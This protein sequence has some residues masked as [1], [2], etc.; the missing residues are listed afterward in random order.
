[1]TVAVTGAS[2]HLGRKVADLILDRLDP[3]AVVLLT[4][5]PDALAAYA[6]RGAVVRRADFD[7]PDLLPE[8]F[9]GVERALLISALDLDRRTGQQRDAIEA[10]KAAGVRHVLYTSI[11][12]ADAGNPAAATPSHRATEEALLDCG[13]AWTFLRNNL[14]AEYQATVVEQAIA[15]GRL[16][17]SAVDGRVAYVSRDDCAAA[18]AAV[19]VQDGHEQQAYDI[20]GPDA[21]GAQDLAALA[22]ELGGRPVDVVA[23]DDEALIVGMIAAGLPEAAARTLASFAVAAREGFLG[24]VSSAFEELTGRR[25]RSLREVVSASREA[26]PAG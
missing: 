3:G 16:V 10:A 4:R 14:Y 18:A 21:I 19:L 20:T 5:T 24:K 25:P 8:A 1:M 23:V 17:T 7:E 9:A 22:T 15:S 11:S 26:S 6:E 12:G 2:G 13:L